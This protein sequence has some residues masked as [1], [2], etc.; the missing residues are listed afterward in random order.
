MAPSTP[1]AV[2]AAPLEDVPKLAEVDPSFAASAIASGGASIV[3][4]PHPEV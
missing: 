1:S 4:E 2:P 3:V